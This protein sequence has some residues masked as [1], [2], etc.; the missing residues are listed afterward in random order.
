MTAALS[1]PEH[2]QLSATALRQALEAAHSK[3]DSIGLNYELMPYRQ[4]DGGTVY[5]DRGVK[6]LMLALAAK[7]NVAPKLANHILIGV[8]TPVGPLRFGPG[9]QVDVD[10]APSASLATLDRA[11]RTYLREVVP[12]AES[13]GIAF[14]SIAFHPDRDPSLINVVSKLHYA[15]MMRRF[16]QSGTRG[17]QMMTCAAGAT[18]LVS[19]RDE[20][21]A[22]DKLRTAV[23]LTPLLQAL[24]ANS[25]IE[26]GKPTGAQ[27]TRVLSWM[28]VDRARTNFFLQALDPEMSYDRYIAWALDVPVLGIDRDG[29]VIDV[30]D[31]S[32]RDNLMSQKL[33]ID[34][35]DW[36]TH[37]RS[38]FPAVR[39]TPRGVEL[40]MADT[41]TPA[42]M[43]ALAALCK[44]LVL[45][46]S[47]RKAV[48]HRLKPA[49]DFVRL[50]QK[51]ARAGLF[52]QSDRGLLLHD[53]Q[54]ALRLAKSELPRDEQRF[55][56]PI[57]Q[58]LQRG[59]SPADE[60]LERY[61]RDWPTPG[62]MMRGTRVTG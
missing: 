46:P 39:L 25:P 15:V 20:G 62:D 42:H 38:L 3:Q 11:L 60:L 43:L 27:S 2:S 33:Y 59:V 48:Q 37:L 18:V 6:P 1:L 32:F 12:V 28:D 51:A 35:G 23:M 13:L 24:F 61:G 10:L 57:E 4:L 50:P 52:A 44:A 21:D 45:S 55:L 53:A 17:L 30:G 34:Q 47:G 58:A 56:E 54:A 19:T 40:R 7:Y 22:I 9:S 31:L 14:S 49:K 29:R 36:R 16:K 26:R 41:G 5:Y 8:D